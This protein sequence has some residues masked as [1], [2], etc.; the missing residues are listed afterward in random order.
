MYL[1]TGCGDTFQSDNFDRIACECTRKRATLRLPPEASR[2][3]LGYDCATLFISKAA[4]FDA[5]WT[6][7]KG[8]ATPGMSSDCNTMYAKQRQRHVVSPARRSTPC[9][10][11]W[12]GSNGSALQPSGRNAH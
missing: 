9:Q 12:D 11:L 2:S 7:E 6:A 1:C 8:S 5:A 4:P 10:V 3:S